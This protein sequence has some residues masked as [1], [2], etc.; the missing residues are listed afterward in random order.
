MSTYKE[1]VGQKITKVSSDP[2]EPKTGQMWYNT[3][4]GS[5][6]GLALVEAWA[7]SSS[8]SLARYNTGSFGIQTD[9]VVAGND[10]TYAVSYTHLRAHET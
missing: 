1:I 4:T 9:A 3:T 8:M 6:R 7:S 10:G 2:G 5:L